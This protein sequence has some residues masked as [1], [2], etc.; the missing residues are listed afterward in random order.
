MF[1]T[2][3]HRRVPQFGKNVRNKQALYPMV[4]K[5]SLSC[6]VVSGWEALAKGAEETAMKALLRCSSGRWSTEL[7][8]RGQAVCSR[9]PRGNQHAA[10]SQL[11][12]FRRCELLR[13]AFLVFHTTSYGT[14][15]CLPRSGDKQPAKHLP[16]GHLP[17]ASPDLRLVC[18]SVPERAPLVAFTG[19]YTARMARTRDLPAPMMTQCQCLHAGLGVRIPGA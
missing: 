13:P 6:A 14:F 10:W 3:L 8:R 15:A 19:C 16:A 18:Q 11:S 12:A 2:Q 5:Q 17:T 1:K 9:G 7:N 4:T